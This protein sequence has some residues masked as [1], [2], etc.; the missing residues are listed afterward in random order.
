M[1][2]TASTTCTKEP[3]ESLKNV[4]YLNLVWGLKSI[5]CAKNLQPCQSVL[6]YSDK[7]LV[8]ME[9]ALIISLP[10]KTEQGAPMLPICWER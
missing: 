9:W 10:L 6:G 8:C 5:V 1:L 7:N 3:T 4:I 2:G